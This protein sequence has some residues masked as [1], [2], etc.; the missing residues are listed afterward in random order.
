MSMY[1]GKDNNNVNLLHI[2]NGVTPK[3][4]IKTGQI[5]ANTVFH[6]SL[7]YLEVEEYSCTV[8]VI[9]NDEMQQVLEIIPAIKF[10]NDVGDKG[11]F[12][13]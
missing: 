8:N 13:H 4:S 7:P 2:T 5:L 11:F 3:S 9:R 12:I 1:I 10:L 6:S